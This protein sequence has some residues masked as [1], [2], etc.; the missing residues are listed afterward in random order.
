MEGAFIIEPEWKSPEINK[1]N[2]ESELI[3]L[4]QDKN[5]SSVVDPILYIKKDLFEMRHP[6]EVNDKSI[7]DEF[8]RDIDEQGF[9]YGNW[10][11]Y[12][13]NSTI[14]RL[15]ESDDYYDLRTFRN[16]NLITKDEQVIL[17]SKKIAA[18]GLSVGSNVVDNLTLSGIGDE[19]LLSDPDRL[20]PINLNRIRLIGC[21][22][23]GLL[24]T[25][26]TGRRIAELDPYL[27]QQH[28]SNGY[29]SETDDILRRERPDAIIEEV[30]NLEIKSKLRNIAKELG[31]PLIMVGDAGD[32]V[33]LDIERHD[34]GQTSIFNG[35]LSKREIE[36]LT[37]GQASKRDQEG[38]FMKLIGINNLSPRLIQ[39]SMLRGQELA[40]FP[41]LGTTAGVAGAVA[42]VALREIFLGRDVPSGTRPAMDIRKTVGSSAPTNMSE[43][44]Q[45]FKDLVNYRKK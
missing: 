12:P 2:S 26:I 21:T 42:S 17:R 45:I 23:L 19:Y 4:T 37:S 20:S 15:P 9:A 44:I 13:W 34:L 3:E 1:I 8:Y 18:F 27:T 30:D 28:F 39:S 35:K 40:G 10:V 14:V 24:K 6:S 38:I 41:Q 31:V 22:G 25:T 16:R 32:K 33:I 36:L 43:N 29:N 5:I 7:E 11:Y